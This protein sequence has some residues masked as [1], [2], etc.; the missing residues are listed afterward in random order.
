MITHG[1]NPGGFR[2][3][4][5]RRPL[6]TPSEEWPQE[7]QPPTNSGLGLRLFG[8]SPVTLS[9]MATSKLPIIGQPF[10][11]SFVKSSFVWLFQACALQSETD[12]ASLV[13]SICKI[14]SQRVFFTHFRAIAVNVT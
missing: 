14:A 6:L 13:S 9:P 2:G 4:R 1:R 10:C 11:A 12:R 7:P 8:V 5:V 3:G